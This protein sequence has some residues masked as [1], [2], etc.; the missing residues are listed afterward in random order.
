MLFRAPD[1]YGEGTVLSVL[2]GGKSDYSG[3]NADLGLKIA[4]R[5]D[6]NCQRTPE[7]LE[8]QPMG[9]LSIKEQ[10]LLG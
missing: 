10:T 5:L 1:L 7:S 3:N 4:W 6:G 9:G 8:T 2:C